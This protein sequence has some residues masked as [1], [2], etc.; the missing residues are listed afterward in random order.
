MPEPKIH[1]VDMV[2]RI[3]EEHYVRLREL[4]PPEKIAFFRKK[5]SA[6]YAELGRHEEVTEYRWKPRVVKAQGGL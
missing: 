3:R 1:A 4:S 2:R 6:L 5:A